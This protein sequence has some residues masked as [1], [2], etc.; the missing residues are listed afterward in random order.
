MQAL[1]L[2]IDGEQHLLHCQNL[3]VECVIR[4]GLL[5]LCC[6]ITYSI[7]YDLISITSISKV[8][9]KPSC[10]YHRFL[11]VCSHKIDLL[12][13]SLLLYSVVFLP[14]VIT[15][16]IIDIFFRLGVPFYW[17][18]FWFSFLIFVLSTLIT[19][20]AFSGSITRM[21]TKVTCCNL[22]R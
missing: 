6:H 21:V 2:T 4:P 9:E 16:V 8:F 3:R 22:P 12:G 10:F 7:A 15:F 1:H 13:Q 5:P 14:L 20:A 19:V 11:P 18:V 17:T